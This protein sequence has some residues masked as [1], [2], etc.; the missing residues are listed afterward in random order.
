MTRARRS[1]QG[2][3]A[4]DERLAE[5]RAWA[6]VRSAYESRESLPEPRRPKRHAFVFAVTLVVAA[7]GLSPAGATVG[8]LITGALGVQHA[9]P[10]LSSLPAPGRLLVSGK[11]GTWV[12][13]AHGSIRR[14]GPW[15]QASWSPHGRYV[16]TARGNQLTVVDPRGTM[17]WLLSRP[18]VSD[19]RWFS[20]S[21]YRV[22]YLS[23]DALRVVAGDGTGDHLLA[24][25]VADVAPA[26]RP[27][28]AY[29][30]A[31][32]TV[33]GTLVVRDGNTGQMLWADR[34]GPGVSE[35]QWSGGGRYLLAVS[36]AAARV[37]DASGALVTKVAA[38][39]GAFAIDGALSPDGRLL[40]L[41]LGGA[42]DQVVL[43][44]VGAHVRS[45]RRL[46]A[47]PGLRQVLW[48]PDGGWLLVSWPAA[49]QWVFI[50]VT[51]TSRI[52][53]VSHIAQQFAAAGET[54]RFPQLEG[55]CCTAR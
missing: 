22:A 43:E 54:S 27:G 20:P 16:A 37:Y 28:H 31:Y 53:A 8:R 10:T 41:V 15:S 51:G 38:P 29:Q 32:L 12:V 24:S 34:L 46:L 11:T 18:S 47:G 1:L 33:G 35:L 44:R 26:W 2:F 4:P 49:D 21:G 52:S 50:S 40:A 19:P 23:G 42:T 9:A 30:V 5:D 6:V 17:Q 55:W 7:V 14:V 39:A 45:P 3:R 13:S 25:S 48:S 36:S